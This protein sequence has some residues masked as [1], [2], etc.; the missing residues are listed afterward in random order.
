MPF[1]PP[2]DGY[3][4]PLFVPAARAYRFL[5]PMCLSLFFVHT[6]HVVV[7]F[8]IVHLTVKLS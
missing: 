8:F 2:S 7:V 4:R 6:V 3:I 5:L 1:L